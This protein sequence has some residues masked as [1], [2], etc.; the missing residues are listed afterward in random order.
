MHPPKIVEKTPQNMGTNNTEN[1]A[2]F[3]LRIVSVDNYMKAPLFGLDTCYSE[4]RADEVK[5]VSGNCLL[6]FF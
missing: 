2:I 3:S 5:Q 6:F 4:F 1:S